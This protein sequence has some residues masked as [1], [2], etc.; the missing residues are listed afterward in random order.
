MN[1][2]PPLAI[3]TTASSPVPSG[4]ICP[5]IS[6]APSAGWIRMPLRRKSEPSQAY[7]PMIFLSENTKGS[8]P[9]G[10]LSFLLDVISSYR[11]WLAVTVGSS[12][13]FLPLQW[14]RGRR[15]CRRGRRGGCYSTRGGRGSLRPDSSNPRRSDICRLVRFRNERKS[16][17]GWKRPFHIRCIV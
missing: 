2:T 4:R 1:T 16:L 11:L 15:R 10:G 5:R 6:S 3:P 12:F 9:D 13:S 8:P 7:E 17:L 14:P